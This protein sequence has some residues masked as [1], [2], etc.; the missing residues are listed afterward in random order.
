M[1]G[2]VK[3]YGL[4]VALEGVDLE[5]AP[6]R[7]Q[8]LVGENGAGKTTLMQILAGHVARD[9]GTIEVDGQQVS[10]ASVPEAYRLGISMVHQHFMLFPSLTVAENLTIGREPRRNGLFDRD[11]ARAAV[12]DLS[13]RYGLGVE[14]DRRVADLSVGALQRVEILRALYRQAGLLI[15]DEPT[16]VLTPQEVRALFGIVRELAADRRTVVFVS[17]HLDEVLELAERVTV[18]RDGRV[19][20]D[21]AASETDVRRLARAM[22]GRDVILRLER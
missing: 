9:A 7:I 1:R 5:L 16:A 14:P 13:A 19:T 20:A 11:G 8:G 22:V 10:L 17:H 21:L 12:A 3:H 4:V 2:I 18:L 15:L 6:G